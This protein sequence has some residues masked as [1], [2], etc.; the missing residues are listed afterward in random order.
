MGIYFGQQSTRTPFGLGGRWTH[1]PRLQRRKVDR[2]LFYRGGRST[3]L[4]CFLEQ[5]GLALAAYDM[6]LRV[7]VGG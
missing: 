6:I 4:Y 2:A 1:Q 7:S 3:E 5:E